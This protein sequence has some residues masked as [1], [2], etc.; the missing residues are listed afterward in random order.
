MAPTPSTNGSASTRVPAWKL[1]GLKLKFAQEDNLLDRQQDF[2][3]APPTANGRK[4]KRDP[5]GKEESLK[6]A[7][8]KLD[9]NG[10]RPSKPPEQQRETEAAH[11]TSDLHSSTLCDPPSTSEPSST[12]KAA[13]R[14]SVS[15]TPDTKKE[16]GDSFKQ[17]FQAWV[18]EQTKEDPSF[19]P[20]KLGEAFKSG[21][22][23]G[24]PEAPEPKI[25]KKQKPKK[26][27][28]Q[29]DPQPTSPDSSDPLHS[30]LAYLL[31]HYQTKDTWKFSKPAQNY[32]L[33]HLFDLNLIPDESPYN[34]ALIGYLQGLQGE[35]RNRVS[36][37]AEELLSQIVPDEPNQEGNLK[38]SAQKAK[39][40][41]LVREA[42]S[43]GATVQTSKS[44][45]GLQNKKVPQEAPVA[46]A[47]EKR[48]PKRSKRRTA[49]VEEDSSESSGSSDAEDDDEA[50]DGDS[51]SSSSLSSLGPNEVDSATDV[52]SSS[53]EER[54]VHYNPDK[55]GDDD[56]S[57]E[58]SESDDSDED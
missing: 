33:K 52:S 1:L 26:T 17:L 53:E 39:R 11:S 25:R 15:F 10:S 57:G 22:P 46:R 24:H 13:R 4:R 8:L 41:G 20:D 19:N 6:S 18:A 48:L 34:E 32:L 47:Q 50:A 38:M 58:S 16:D 36:E 31:Q 37:K 9:L 5:D 28:S 44:S 7:K 2:A 51:D 23:E 30:A 42:L 40:A 56:E 54:E 29:S 49:A 35:A 45:A 27:K 12:K 43:S 55:S 21:S 3:E 14:K